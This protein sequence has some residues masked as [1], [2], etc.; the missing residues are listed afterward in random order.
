MKVQREA[1]NLLLLGGSIGNFFSLGRTKQGA[2][3]HQ[4]A[5]TQS[6]PPKPPKFRAP[7]SFKGTKILLTRNPWSPKLGKT[8]DSWE[9]TSG[10]PNASKVRIPYWEEE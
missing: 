5:K 4:E 8:L 2:G 6:F 3:A 7:R 10:T 1:Q 9:A